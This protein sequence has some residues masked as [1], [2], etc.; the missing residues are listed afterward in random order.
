MRIVH[1]AAA[2]DSNTDR[3]VRLLSDPL[4][5]LAPHVRRVCVSTLVQ[6]RE[7]TSLMNKISPCSPVLQAS[8]SLYLRAITWKDIDEQSRSSFVSQFGSLTEL[9]FSNMKFGTFDDMAGFLASFP[10]LQ[11]LYFV[12]VQWQGG[13]PR[14]DSPAL[15]LILPKLKTLEVDYGCNDVIEWLRVCDKNFPRVSKFH[16]KMSDIMPSSEAFSPAFAPS[17][18]HVEIGFY[19]LYHGAFSTFLYNIS[20]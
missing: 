12:R 18:E 15:D 5:T 9:V 19:R 7:L 17:L 2:V 4:S 6:Q 16:L 20:S 8:K 11:R 13:P 1:F 14:A 10:N 3:L